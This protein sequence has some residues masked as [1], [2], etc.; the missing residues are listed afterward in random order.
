VDPTGFCSL[1][2]CAS[3]CAAAS[4][5]HPGAVLSPPGGAGSRHR[6]FLWWHKEPCHTPR[7]AAFLHLRNELCH[8]K[9]TSCALLDFVLKIAVMRHVTVHMSFET[10]IQRVSNGTCHPY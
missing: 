9:T 3:G 7:H 4:A 6:Y 2:R 10:G 1:L 5:A 8:T